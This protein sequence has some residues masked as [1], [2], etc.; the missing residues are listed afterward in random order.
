MKTRINNMHSNAKRQ[1]Q[2]A[3]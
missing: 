3:V 1:G 2:Q